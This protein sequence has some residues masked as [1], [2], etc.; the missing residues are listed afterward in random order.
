MRSEA[1]LAEASREADGIVMLGLSHTGTTAALVRQ[2][3]RLRRIQ[4]TTAGYGGIT[5]H[6]V[7]VG[8]MITNAGHSLTKSP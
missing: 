2:M 6:G 8:M 1:D 7:P 3:D 5:F 4:L